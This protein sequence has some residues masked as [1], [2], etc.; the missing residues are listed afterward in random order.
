MDPVLT[1]DWADTGQ[2]FG[3]PLLCP[4]QGIGAGVIVFSFAF[5][6]VGQGAFSF[7]QGLLSKGWQLLQLSH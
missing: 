3:C 1:H 5:G 6:N 2:R 7:D 4:L